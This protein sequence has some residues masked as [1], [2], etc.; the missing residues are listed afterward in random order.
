MVLAAGAL[1]ACEVYESPSRGQDDSGDKV[2]YLEQYDPIADNGQ[3]WHPE[4]AAVPWRYV[5]IANVAN[6]TGN[7]DLGRTDVNQGLQAHLMAQSAAGILNRA[8]KNGTGEYGV[9]LRDESDPNMTAYKLSKEYVTYEAGAEDW[10]VCVPQ[11][12]ATA[13]GELNPQ[14]SGYVLTDVESNPES[15]IVASVAAHVYNAV[16]VDVRD[17]AYYEQSPHLTMLYDA[18]DKTTADSWREFRDY[19]N[20]KALVVMPVQTAN[21]REFSIT[22]ELFVINLNKTF[23]TPINGQ[24]VDIFEEVLAW[25][26]PNSPV[27]GWEQG[28]GEDEFVNLVSRYG[29][30]MVPYDWAYNTSFTSMNYKQRQKSVLAKVTNPQFIDWESTKKKF[31]SFY[32][33]DGDNIQWMINNFESADYYTHPLAKQTKLTFGMGAA[34]LSMVAPAQFEYLLSLQNAE[35]SIME[36]L[37]GGY[38]YVDTFAERGNRATALRK[39]AKDM[40]SHMRQHR[41]K[42]LGLVA[43]DPTGDKAK[44]AYQEFIS[45]NN[46]L[47][48]IVVIGYAPYAGGK[49]EIMWFTNSDGIDIPVVSVKYSIWN[50]NTYNAERE[51]T[52]TYIAHRLNEEDTETVTPFSAVSVHAWSRF[53]DIGDSQDELAECTG[54]NEVGAGAAQLCINKLDDDIEIVP[55]EELIW[56]VRM[57]YRPEQTQEILTRVF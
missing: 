14:I 10:S 32:L 48:G 4:F 12:I 57:Y 53:A 9:W 35:N 1:A 17:Q 15:A 23:G 13:Y 56:R 51:G 46:Q 38:Y 6:V 41:I 3:Y 37:G 43:M 27:Y 25:L 21:L 30:M 52:P 11:Q 7:N 24:N 19:C 50:Y 42:L 47:E 44:R 2:L 39:I 18:R 16:I 5:T 26:E 54:G 8:V 34:N 33:S 55:M 49:G 22:H 45:A 20:N 36:N 40:S 29:H 28:V 31:V